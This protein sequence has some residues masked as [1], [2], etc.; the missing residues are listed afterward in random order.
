MLAGPTLLRGPV[1]VSTS[2]QRHPSANDPA[3]DADVGDVSLL[4]TVTRVETPEHFSFTFELAGPM[5]RAVAYAIDLA[6]R[7]VILMVL[8]W[9]G[10]IAGIFGFWDADGLAIGVLLVLAFVLEWGYFV[11]LELAWDGRSVGKRALGLRVVSADGRPLGAGNVF[12]RNL[13]RAA[14]FLPSLYALGLLVMSTDARFRRLGDTVAGTLVVYERR[15]RIEN[16]LFIHPPPTPAELSSL[17]QRPNLSTKDLEALELFLRRI[18]QYPEARLYELAELIA[19]T[20]AERLGIRYRNPIRFLAV[21][22]HRAAQLRV[23]PI[24]GTPDAR[25][26]GFR[27]THP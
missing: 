21:L 25:R 22:Y 2:K 9:V 13:L 23:V 11:V 3:V 7:G 26:G 5:R 14:D 1:S 8:V 16:E 15:E 6:V 19:P 27:A 18:H 10:A 12:L 4:D 20:Y 17:P 24:P